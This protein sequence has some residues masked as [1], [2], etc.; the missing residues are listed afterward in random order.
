MPRFKPPSDLRSRFDPS[1][2]SSSSKR[3]ARTCSRWYRTTVTQSAC[4]G[5]RPGSC[6][7]PLVVVQQV[8]ASRLWGQIHGPI[9]CNLG[10]TIVTRA[11]R[12]HGDIIIK[13]SRRRMRR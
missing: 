11:D 9:E 1:D 3:S 10:H 2:R 4:M 7:H 6:S 8:P 5:D 12:S 13:I